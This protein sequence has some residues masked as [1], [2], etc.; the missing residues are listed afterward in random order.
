MSP[1][2]TP[3]P[4]DALLEVDR[5]R[6]EVVELRERTAQLQRA[7]ESRLDIPTDTAFTLLRRAARSEQMRIHDLAALVV[8]ASATPP[9]VAREVACSRPEEV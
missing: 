2:S 7:L 5:L 4:R 9:P 8:G 3:E 6:A 1:V